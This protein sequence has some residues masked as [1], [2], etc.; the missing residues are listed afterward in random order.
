MK[1]PYKSLAFQVLVGIILGVLIGIFLPTWGANVKLLSDVFIRLVKLV[2]G[3]VIFCTIVNG[4]SNHADVKAAGRIGLLAIIYFEIITTFALLIGLFS[5]HLLKPGVGIDVSHVDT[6]DAA[7][8][9]IKA[10]PMSAYDHIL[11][12]FPSSFVDAFAQNNLLQILFFSIIFGIAMA[13]LGDKVAPLKSMIKQ[14]EQVVFKIL[15]FI[16]S[17]APVAAFGAMA[18]T[19][20]HFGTHVLVNFGE[21]IAS[22]YLTAAVFIFIVL[23]GV[24]RLFG[25]R[26]WTLLKFVKEEILITVGTSSSEAALPRLMKKLESFGCRKEVV[27]L[28]VPTGY[29]FNLDGTSIYLSAAALFIAQAYGIELTVLQQASIIAILMLNSKGAA[30]VT[31]GGFVTLAATLSATNMLPVEGLVLLIGVDRFMSQIRALTNVIGNSVATVVV[32]KW[33]ARRRVKQS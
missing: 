23:G 31:G 27:G 32:S 7:S 6:A 15:N 19:V 2:V 12:I 13:L 26:L 18:Y 30:A 28:V 29:S 3:P 21:L 33:E 1:L 5:T 16:V 22:V 9:V 8:Y 10:T 17:I 11:S 25:F 24:C 14:F 20:S 4:I